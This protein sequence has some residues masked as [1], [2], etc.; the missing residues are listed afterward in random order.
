[1]IKTEDEEIN[2]LLNRAEEYRKKM[3]ENEFQEKSIKLQIDTNLGDIFKCFFQGKK[4]LDDNSK[5]NIFINYK[6]DKNELRNGCLKIV[7]YKSTEKDNKKLSKK[8][9]VKFPPNTKMGQKIIIY[10]GGNYIKETNSYSNL[11]I[12]IMDK[13]RRK[14]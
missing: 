10:H 5:N 3:K 12:T 8:I 13:K 11:I 2:K 14:Q 6:L 1:M 4:K 7:K 9:E